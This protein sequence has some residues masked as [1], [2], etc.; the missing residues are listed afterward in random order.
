MW[1]F[2]LFLYRFSASYTP[3]GIRIVRFM[4]VPAPVCLVPGPSGAD[5]GGRTRRGDNDGD[6]FIKLPKTA[7]NRLTN[8]PF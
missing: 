4:P 6:T 7:R 8:H 3:S 5:Y 1:G 2:S